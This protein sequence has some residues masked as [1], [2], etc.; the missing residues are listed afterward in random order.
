[1]SL[2]SKKTNSNKVAVKLLYYNYIM[3]REDGNKLKKKK[4][5]NN[6]RIILG[7]VGGEGMI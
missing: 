5:K 7:K 3:F 6:I 1:M 2:K 4:I